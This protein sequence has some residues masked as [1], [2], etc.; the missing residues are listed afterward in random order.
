MLRKIYKFIDDSIIRNDMVIVTTFC[1]FAIILFV[2]SMRFLVDYTPATDKDYTPLIEQQEVISKDFDKVYNY[3]NFTITSAG[4]NTITV[5]FENDQ[6]KLISSFDRER[7]FIENKKIDKAMPVFGAI[8]ISLLFFSIMCNA[9]IIF[10]IAGILYVISLL[11][12]LLEKI[13]RLLI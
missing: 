13:C 2:L 10:I 11:L 8:F 9:L 5:T 4:K 7:N 6:C 1:L 3:D 12:K